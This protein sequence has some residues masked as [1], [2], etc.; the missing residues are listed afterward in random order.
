M[1]P[2]SITPRF[3]NCRTLRQAGYAASHSSHL[4]SDLRSSSHRN[5]SLV[6]MLR[7]PAHPADV[8]EVSLLPTPGTKGSGDQRPGEWASACNGGSGCRPSSCS[9]GL[10]AWVS[11]TRNR[12]CQNPG[13]PPRAEKKK[14]QGWLR[15]QTFAGSPVHVT[16]KRN[17]ARTKGTP[18]LSFPI[19]S[20]LVIVNQR[21]YARN[22]K[23][24]DSKTGPT[25]LG[26]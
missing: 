7:W 25:W 22:P 11:A 13:L 20:A 5:H 2:P 14:T 1:Q 19:R 15:P 16:K 12:V 26:R 4:T 17:D 21:S 8:N 3:L 24:R 10:K 9:C 18:L 23:S 6:E